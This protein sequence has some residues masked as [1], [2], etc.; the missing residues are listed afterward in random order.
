MN[1][2][3]EAQYEEFCQQYIIDFNG[4]RAAQAA[5]FG[6]TTMSSSVQASRLLS[7]VK[8][9]KRLAELMADRSERTKITQDRVL[10]EL[11]L[12]GFSDFKDYGQ[13]DD[14]GNLVFTPFKDVGEEKTRAIESLKQSDTQS[15]RT[16]SMKLH[17]KTRPLELIGKHLGMFADTHNVNLTGDITVISAVPRPKRKKEKET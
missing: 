13:I 5:G 14:D 8:I 12:L 16:I 6:N 15:G 11:A 2:K 1:K 3:L 10:E 17:G 9:Q 4:T 7:K